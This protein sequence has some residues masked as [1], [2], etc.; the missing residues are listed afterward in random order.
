LHKIESD[1]EETEMKRD[2]SN[3]RPRS[4]EFVSTGNGMAPPPY[5]PYI[6]SVISDFSNELNDPSH[7]ISNVTQAL[8]LWAGSGLEEEQFTELLYEAK[9]VTRTYQGKQGLNG[10]DNKMAYFFKVVRD[11]CNVS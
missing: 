8:R 3:Q 7:V 2:D 4:N 11:L 6:A 10:I 5:S 1:K 9:R